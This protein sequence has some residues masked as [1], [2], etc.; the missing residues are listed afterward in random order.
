MALNF[1]VYYY[2][3]LNYIKIIHAIGQISNIEYYYLQTS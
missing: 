1:L 3:K 2:A